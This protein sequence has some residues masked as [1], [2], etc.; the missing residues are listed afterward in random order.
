MIQIILILLI[1]HYI[2]LYIFKPKHNTLNCGLFGFAGKTPKSFNKDKFDKLGIYNI[3]RGKSSCGISYDGDI[4][5]GIDSNKLYTD[6]IV[7][8]DI[9]PKRFP[10]VIGHTRQSSVGSVNVYNAHPFGF[11]DNNGDFIF[12]GT[13]NGTLK[14]HIEL[15][16]K[17][18]IEKT[19]KNTFYDK[20]DTEVVVNR[21]KIDSEIL[22]EIIYKH[23]NFK[24]LNDYIG[25]AALAFTDTTSPNVLY[26]FKGKSKDWA[27]STH[28]TTERPLFVYIENKNSMYYSSLEESLRTIGGND[29]NIIDIESNVVYKITDGDFKNAELI[30]ISRSNATQNLSYSKQNNYHFNTYEFF[31]EEFDYQNHNET[32]HTNTKKEKE[33]EEVRSLINLPALKEVNKDNGF[34]NIYEEKPLKHINDYRSIPYFNKLR[35]F[36]NGHLLTGIYVWI[37]QYGFYNIGTTIKNATERFYYIVDKVFDGESFISEDINVKGKIPFQ[38]SE[39]INPSFF[40]FVE[41]VQIRTSMDYAHFYHKF[42]II[43]SGNFIDYIELSHVAVHPVIN[44]NFKLKDINQQNIVKNGISYSGTTTV[45]GAEKIYNIKHGNLIDTKTSLYFSN[46]KE[47]YYKIEE[48]PIKLSMENKISDFENVLFKVNDNLEILEQNDELLLEEMIA[49][50]EEVEQIIRDICDEDFTEPIKDFQQI[51]NK[52]LKYSENNLAV[53]VISFI[54]NTMQNM[55]EFIN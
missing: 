54:D 52:V 17:Y 1:I 49:Q 35:W 16:K 5:I 27:V 51:R 28:E 19:A 55:K 21:D 30:H 15:A 41:G 31:S 26:L 42:S 38:S 36:R 33:E 4:Q 43:K 11:G 44:L 12:I 39:C 32:S 23:K 48:E 20:L 10:I 24:V 45:L 18:D 6:F 9:K 37:N 50:E 8:K 14:N 13:H 22:L 47:D 7:D 53:K 3:E 25:G 40:Y 29:N 2:G 46:M 34:I